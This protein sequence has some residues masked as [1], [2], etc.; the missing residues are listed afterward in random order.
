MQVILYQKTAGVMGSVWPEV[1]A[2]AAD[3][4]LLLPSAEVLCIA[5]HAMDLEQQLLMVASGAP[6][7]AAKNQRASSP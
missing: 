2:Y 1:C 6:A 4:Q 5:P 7:S 3:V